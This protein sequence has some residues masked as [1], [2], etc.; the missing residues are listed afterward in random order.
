MPADEVVSPSSCGPFSALRASLLG[1]IDAD[2]DWSPSQM[3]CENMMRPERDGARLRFSGQQ[4]GKTLA[5][6]LALPGLA[7]GQNGIEVPT[8]VTVS[9]EGTGRFFS[10]P[11]LQTCWTEVRTHVPDDDIANLHRIGG[12]L[13][14]VAALGE[15]NSTDFVEISTLT[16]SSSID[17][18]KP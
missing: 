4:D 18:S 6:I 16:F 3:H 9:I 12:E 15:L 1:G 14:C 13:Y 10:T 2:V 5:I 8:N 7:A 11:D 17:W